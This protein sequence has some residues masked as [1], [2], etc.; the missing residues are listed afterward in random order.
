MTT[1]NSQKIGQKQKTCK[2]QKH[3]YVKDNKMY[4]NDYYWHRI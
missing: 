4:Y 2:T 1:K 3:I